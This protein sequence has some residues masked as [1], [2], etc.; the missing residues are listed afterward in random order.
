MKT[1][2]NKKTATSVR[3]ENGATIIRYHNTD[4]VSFTSDTVTLNSGG[5][6]TAT[7]KRRMNEVAE[8][9]GL[10]FQVWQHSGDWFV[11]RPDGGEMP[12]ADSMT[13]GRF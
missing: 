10:G 7:T 6:R 4:I 11:R 8:T 13:L 9:F 5:W 12:F 2:I 1:A 3:T